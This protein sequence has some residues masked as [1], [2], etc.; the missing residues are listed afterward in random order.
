[1]TGVAGPGPGG[2]TAGGSSGGG[3]DEAAGE[4]VAAAPDERAAAPA[5]DY[6]LR[7][8]GIG[9]SFGRLTVLKSA[10]LWAR[11]GE[12]TTLMG[13]NGVGKTTLM[14]VAAG[15]L[16]P[17]HGFVRMGDY[18]AERP[19]LCRLAREGL[20]YIPQEQLLSSAFT[21]ERHM[22]AVASRWA[23][24]DGDERV[25]EV[26]EELELETVR[27]QPVP[28]LSG[29]ER[30]RASLALGLIRRPRCLLVDEPLTGLAPMDQ[31]RV[32]GILRR[33]AAGGTAVVAS[34]HDVGELMALS[35]RIIWCVAGTTHGL[36]T[37]EEAAR[38]PQFVREYL[39]PRRI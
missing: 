37:P 10:S 18:A 35:D 3:G 21:V 27:S 36:G 2:P 30:M 17:D 11:P 38:H 20:F 26:V 15:V 29:G 32:G 5:G 13:R 22:R 16:W 9:K 14:R 31:A 34:G 6:L 19:R 39:G 4:A 33:M 23:G 24:K 7:A 25:E 12:V 1:M 28:Q 8:E